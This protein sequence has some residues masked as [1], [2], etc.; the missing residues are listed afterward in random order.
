MP[1]VRLLPQDDIFAAPAGAALGDLLFA[2]GVEQ[3]CG[4]RGRCRGCRVQVVAGALAPG[5]D[6]RASFSAVEL[7]QGWR[8]GCRA[9][10]DA[11][12]TVA[13]G[14]WS[15]P[16]LA[17]DTPLV[18]EPRDGL[19][20]A[21]DLGSTTLVAQLVDRSNGQVL[22]VRT[23]LN[24]QARRGADIMTRID[25]AMHGGAAELTALVRAELGRLV[26]E[27][28][29]AHPG[30][31]RLVTVAGN[32]VMHHLFAGHDLAPLAAPPYEPAQSGAATLDGGDLGWAGCAGC[33]VVA[34]PCLG[35]FVGGDILAG[36]LATGMGQDPRPSALIDL[37]TNGE[38]AVSDGSRIVCA[39]TAAG[40]AFEGA[41]I[42]CGMRA[43]TGAVSTVRVDGDGLAVTVLGGGA[44]RGVCG[45]GLID[46]CAAARRLGW[47]AGTGRIKREDR[48]IPL[49]PGVALTQADVRQVQ[50]AK[51][52]VAAGFDLL[53]RRL[54]LRAQD[55]GRVWLA[56]AFGNAIDRASAHAVG[57]LPLPP[58][59]VTPAGN[60]ALLGARLALSHDDHAYAALRAR[61][62]H[63]ALKQDE[64]FED[65]Y[66]E[67]MAFP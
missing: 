4:G 61:C 66:L 11:D 57:L 43:A 30:T 50:L 46:A 34:L 63:V 60:T 23:A 52:A 36:L 2:H 28:L 35:G 32:S 47:L 40:P 17:D 10:V 56:G 18:L 29:A 8:L 16:V 59:R 62:T 38:I 45:S 20:I 19:G 24:P 49:A 48:L 39:S 13:L 26:A 15:S 22:G 9:R 41:A 14:R 33:P 64:A 58:E 51:G 67:G 42:S 27:L 7:A 55:L 3:P 53:L 12:L 21:I 37:G 5:D 65:A 31:P 54:G 25:H 1:R 6:D 44:A